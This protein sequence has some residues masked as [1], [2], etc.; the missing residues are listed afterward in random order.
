MKRWDKK[1]RGN[2]E[3]SKSYAA[4]ITEA[5]VVQY[6][7]STSWNLDEDHTEELHVYC[8]GSVE[9]NDKI[10]GKRKM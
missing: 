3:G 8:I 6:I 2:L 5:T 7:S 9:T 1:K 4:A 10:K